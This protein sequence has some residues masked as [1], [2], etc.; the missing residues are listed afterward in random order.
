MGEKT[1]EE[2]LAWLEKMVGVYGYMLAM[3]DGRN[4]RGYLASTI[5]FDLW[6]EGLTDK[7]WRWLWDEIV[8]PLMKEARFRGEIAGEK[9]PCG[10]S[11]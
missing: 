2:R 10:N 7:E 8:P 6:L 1:V 11:P 9:Q 5:G 4:I 3:E